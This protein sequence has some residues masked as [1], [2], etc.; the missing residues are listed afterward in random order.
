[1]SSRDRPAAPI[2]HGPL[3]EPRPP[4][5]PTTILI[6]CLLLATPAPLRAEEETVAVPRETAGALAALPARGLAAAIAEAGRIEVLVGPVEIDGPRRGTK[7][8][9]LR[10][11]AIRACRL[12]PARRQPRRPVG[13]QRIPLTECA[14]QWVGSE[15]H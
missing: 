11:R 10:P 1:M 4:C 12:D 6:A 13:R 15:S 2:R 7:V 8:A 5:A 9:H 3:C 14:A